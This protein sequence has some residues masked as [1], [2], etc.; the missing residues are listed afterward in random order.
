[1][2]GRGPDAVLRRPLQGSR[3]SPQ[4]PNLAEKAARA[5]FGNEGAGT[6]GGTTI[7]HRIANLRRRMGGGTLDTEIN[8]VTLT[9]TVSGPPR[10]ERVEDGIPRLLFALEQARGRARIPNRFRCVAFG[11]LA[12]EV[13]EGVHEGDHVLVA[14]ELS[15]AR[16]AERGR[17]RR[18]PRGEGAQS[19]QGRWARKRRRRLLGRIFESANMRIFAN[20]CLR[21]RM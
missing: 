13:F 4:S 10:L 9:G 15:E 3:G 11:P 16:Q 21:I 7:N 1:M 20:M 14:G 2:P 19:L 17:A 8:A 5:T 18:G 6:A 12:I